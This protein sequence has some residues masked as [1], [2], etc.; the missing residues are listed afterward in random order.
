[1][2]AGVWGGHN[3]PA[4][5][6]AHV[7]T[8]AHTPARALLRA[9]EE[10]LVRHV[11]V[12]NFDVPRMQEMMDAGVMIVSNQASER[13][14]EEG[15]WTGWRRAGQERM[16]DWQGRR[17]SS[18]TR[19]RPPAPVSQTRTLSGPILAAGSAARRGDG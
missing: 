19:V 18:H 11:G 1:M 10:G 9:Q 12:T 3:V 13:A 15:V 6:G 8:R 7:H 16:D 5:V 4:C 14:S 2:R 17:L